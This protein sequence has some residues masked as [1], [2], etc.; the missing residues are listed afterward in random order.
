MNRCCMDTCVWDSWKTSPRDHFLGPGSQLPTKR[1]HIYDSLEWWGIPAECVVGAYHARI[2]QL[3]QSGTCYRLQRCRSHRLTI[4]LR[5]QHFISLPTI[6]KPNLHFRLKLSIRDRDDKFLASFWIEL[7]RNLAISMLSWGSRFDFNLTMEGYGLKAQCGCNLHFRSSRRLQASVSMWVR[8]PLVSFF[9]SPPTLLKSLLETQGFQ[10][11]FRS[12]IET[13]LETCRVFCGIA[14]IEA[15]MEWIGHGEV[16]EC[17][18]D[19]VAHAAGF[20]FVLRTKTV[21]SDQ[22]QRRFLSA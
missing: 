4:A 9:E 2:S 18:S 1:P 8:P 11:R 5:G 15:E 13:R 10:S 6:Q 22:R 16:R 17:G 20:G 7:A 19:I 3:I 12:P 14:F 21:I